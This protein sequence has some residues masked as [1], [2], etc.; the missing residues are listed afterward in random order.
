M[1]VSAEEASRLGR[2]IDALSSDISRRANTV[3]AALH[4]L[5]TPRQPSL[6]RMSRTQQKKLGKTFLEFSGRFEQVQKEYR[7]KYRQQLERQYLIVNPTASRSELD[8]LSSE[9][10]GQKVRI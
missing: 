7:Q 3:R 10:S 1:A 6:A 5:S 2:E 8:A 9:D 4:S